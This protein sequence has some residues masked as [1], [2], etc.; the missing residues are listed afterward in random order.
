MNKPAPIVVAVGT[1]GCDAALQYA[2]REAVLLGAPLHLVHNLKIPAKD[3][4]AA[5]IYQDVL[6][7]SNGILDKAA[8]SARALTNGRVSVT[9]TLWDQSPTSASLLA[10]SQEAQQIVMQHRHLFPA[11]R[12]FAGSTVC[13]VA[14]RAQVPVVVVPPNWYPGEARR[15]VVAAVQDGL[16]APAV[17]RSAY[18]EAERRGAE[19]VILHAWWLNS[20]FDVVAVDDDYRRQRAAEFE[21]ELTS[22]TEA[23]TDEWPDVHATVAVVHAPPAEALLDW[24]KRSDLLVIGRRHHLLPLGSHLGPVA[25]AVL[26]HSECPVLVA[27]EAPADVAARASLTHAIRHPYRPGVMY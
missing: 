22:I 6:E 10:S 13:G 5:G 15:P 2:A 24:A 9:S 25:R 1:T 4:S 19:V 23:M 20:G 26:H 7:E 21:H 12:F 14:A 11:R 8:E 3:A 27:P 16:E 17:L 18:G